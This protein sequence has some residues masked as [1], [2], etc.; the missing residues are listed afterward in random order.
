MTRFSHTLFLALFSL[1][2]HFFV[3]FYPPSHSLDLPISSRPSLPKLPILS[4]RQPHSPPSVLHISFLSHS[5]PSLS[6]PS[7]V[8]PTPLSRSLNLHLP[9]SLHFPIL[10]PLPLSSTFHP[11]IVS[12]SIPI[13]LD[14]SP[15]PF[16]LPHS[17]Y[18]FLFAP[19]YSTLFSPI[20]S[21]PTFFRFDSFSLFSRVLPLLFLCLHSVLSCTLMFLI[22]RVMESLKGG[23]KLGVS[24]FYSETGI[25]DGVTDIGPGSRTEWEWGFTHVSRGRVGT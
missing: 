13:R 4:H 1:S 2:S 9:H 24:R 7:F 16:F 17:F 10:T 5:L 21:T 22:P 20:L 19:T 18:P 12:H 11:C 6:P 8:A 25:R 23:R 14:N 3:H 15:S